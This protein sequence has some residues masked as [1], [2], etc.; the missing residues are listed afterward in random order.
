MNKFLKI[1]RQIL[2]LQITFSATTQALA[3]GGS[4][5]RYVGE[6]HPPIIV[7]DA[8]K[9][10]AVLFL[11]NN[12]KKSIENTHVATGEIYY[13]QVQPLTPELK[14]V[15]K[16]EGDH[17]SSVFFYDWKTP[18]RAGR[19]MYVLMKTV[20]SNRIFEGL[21]YTA[22][23]LSVISEGDKLSLNFFPGDLQ[24]S[25][26]QNCYEGLYLEDSKIVTCAY[27]NASDIKKYLALQ[28]K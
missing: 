17:V 23:E 25:K 8:G 9:K 6:L 12:F 3:A 19:S 10:M 22:M 16:V 18:E 24:D 28:D 11:K 26:L 1:F 7:S 21:S 27:K 5:P 14:Y 4:D 15:W 2:I 20:V 13:F